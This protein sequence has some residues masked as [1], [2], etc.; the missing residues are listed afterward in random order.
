[1]KG[2]SVFFMQIL[3]TQ[4]ILSVFFILISIL[5]IL[6]L[7]KKSKAIELLLESIYPE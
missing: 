4:P 5:L 6:S 7:L 1:M 2:L 3:D